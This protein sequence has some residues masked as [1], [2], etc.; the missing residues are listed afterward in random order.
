VF[1]RNHLLAIEHEGPR[2]MARVGV[3]QAVLSRVDH[4]V[5]DSE[6]LVCSVPDIGGQLTSSCPDL[7]SW[8]VA[9]GEGRATA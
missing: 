6:V 2:E 4:A 9:E 1:Q 3:E 8:F 7:S 5:E